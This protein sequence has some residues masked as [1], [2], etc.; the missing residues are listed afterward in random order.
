MLHSEDKE[1]SKIQKEFTGFEI[2]KMMLKLLEEYGYEV[3]NQKSIRN[4]ID[5][6]FFTYTQKIQCFEFILVIIIG[7]VF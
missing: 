2:S 4:T 7:G 6:Y 1:N 5:Y 3:K